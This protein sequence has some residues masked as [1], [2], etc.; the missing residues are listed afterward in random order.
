MKPFLDS[1]SLDRACDEI[2]RLQIYSNDHDR[3]D[4][5]E[6]IIKYL[7]WEL[8]KERGMDLLT[9]VTRND[10]AFFCAAML[11]AHPDMDNDMA[12]I[13]ITT[14]IKINLRELG[15]LPRK[16]SDGALPYQALRVRSRRRTLSISRSAERGA[17]PEH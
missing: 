3:I 7:S 15:K 4:F 5:R 17:G 1:Y 12:L 13:A 8:R 6:T 11:T 9:L 10:I 14:G 2:A 16:D